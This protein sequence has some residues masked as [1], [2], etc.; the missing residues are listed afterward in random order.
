MPINNP[1]TSDE[2]KLREEARRWLTRIL[3]KDTPAMRR[4]LRQWRDESPAH[5]AAFRQIEAAWQSSRQ[6]ADRIAQGED[7]ELRAYLDEMDRRKVQRSKTRRRLTALS[8]GFVLLVSGAAWMEKPNLLQDLLADHVAARGERLVVRLADGTA[9]LLDADSALDDDF[10]PGERRVR[11]LRGAAFFDVK[12]SQV[13]FVVEAANGQVSVLGTRFDV[14]L[15]GD[16]AAITLAEGRVAVSS[17]AS[18]SQGAELSP[19][20]QI[21]VT[22]TGIGTAAAIN[23]EDAMAWHEG[24]FV[25]YRARLGDVVAQIERYRP[26]RIVIATQALSNERVTGS[27][28]LDDPVGA[29]ASLQATVGFRTVSLGNRLTVV[30][31]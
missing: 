5:D 19:G 2:P 22:A 30:S 4:N 23:L 12:P 16:G 9:V 1:S 15:D 20:Q 31:P 11:L 7:D 24:R 8:L 26:G 18:P 25:F 10:R 6:I 13:P 21:H 27:F 17:P 29:L 14:R 3:Q 28:R